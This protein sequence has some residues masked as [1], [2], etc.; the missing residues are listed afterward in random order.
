MGACLTRY[1]KDV[2]ADLMEIRGIPEHIRSDNGYFE[3]FNGKLRNLT[4]K[5]DQ[6]MQADQ[7]GE[8]L[9][10]IWKSPV[11]GKEYQPSA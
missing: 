8:D 4:L 7:I 2:F 5:L 6:L 3:P 9:T 10:I 11:C 1:K